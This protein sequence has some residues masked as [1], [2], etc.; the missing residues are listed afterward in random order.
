MFHCFLFP[1]QSNVTGLSLKFLQKL[2]VN[3]APVSS[4]PFLMRAHQLPD[5]QWS[6]CSGLCNW[7]VFSARISDSSAPEYLLIKFISII[8]GKERFTLLEYLKLILLEFFY[9]SGATA[10]HLLQINVH[11]WKHLWHLGITGWFLS[12]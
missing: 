1:T 12:S 5:S 10:E 3:R 4:R 2:M 11:N 6:L 9:S 7:C 8:M